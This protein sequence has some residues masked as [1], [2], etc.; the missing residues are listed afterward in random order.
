MTDIEEI[1]SLITNNT[2][3]VEEIRDLVDIVNVI[4]EVILLLKKGKNHIGICPFCAEKTPNFTVSPEK[5]MFYCFE[6]GVGGNVFK[7]VMEYENVPFPEAVQK[8]VNKYNI[9]LE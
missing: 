4:S 9:K 6:C 1:K 2:D 5:Q 8:I 3:K 7:F